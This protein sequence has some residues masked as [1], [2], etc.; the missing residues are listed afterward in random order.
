ME[1]RIKVALFTVGVDIGLG[2]G[3]M[4]W[5]SPYTLWIALFLTVNLGGVI[6]IGLL[7]KYE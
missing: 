2:L 3:Y 4:T 1:R 5:P 6:W 7:R